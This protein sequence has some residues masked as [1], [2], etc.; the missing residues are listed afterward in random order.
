MKNNNHQKNTFPFWLT[1]ISYLIILIMPFFA[2]LFLGY[3]TK[4]YIQNIWF[5]TM[6]IAVTIVVIY[7][8]IRIKNNSHLELTLPA[9]IEE[10]RKVQ[11]IESAKQISLYQ[12][13]I[14][15]IKA[16]KSEYDNIE[17][18]SLSLLGIQGIVKLVFR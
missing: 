4:D 16:I 15:K 3:S 18:L 10:L 9:Q 1:V 8:K 11:M 12:T 6:I 2:V 13:K 7:Y 14:E 17:I 5:E